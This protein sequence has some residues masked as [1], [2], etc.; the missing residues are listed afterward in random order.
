MAKI[1]SLTATAM[2]A[3]GLAGV[4]Q[5][6][7]NGDCIPDG[8]EEYAVL[9]CKALKNGAIEVFAFSNAG[10]HAPEI[11]IGD[12]CVDALNT[13]HNQGD[14]AGNRY[15]IVDSRAN[16]VSTGTPDKTIYTTK[17]FGEYDCP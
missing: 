12:D 10:G 15:F 4:A 13:L 2:L 16:G 6:G 11:N 14:I 8:E 17:A 9:E 1:A 3:L 5:A 7:S